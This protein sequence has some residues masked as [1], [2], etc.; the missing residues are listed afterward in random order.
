[1]GELLLDTEQQAGS[2]CG[3]PRAW[4]FIRPVISEV[5]N[6]ERLTGQS[7]TP[8][9]LLRKPEVGDQG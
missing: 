2:E 4:L 5:Y 3:F 7:I 6:L 8:A 9:V 1:M